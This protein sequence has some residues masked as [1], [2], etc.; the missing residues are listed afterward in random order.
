MRL[1]ES[2][3]NQFLFA[4]R[5]HFRNQLLTGC[6]VTVVMLMPQYTKVGVL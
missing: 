5:E 6:K 3:E 2:K 4:E 1:S